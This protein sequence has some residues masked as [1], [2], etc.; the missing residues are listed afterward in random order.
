MS[1]FDFLADPKIL[2]VAENAAERVRARV[3]A[4]VRGEELLGACLDD[5]RATGYHTLT[6]PSALGGLG[7]SVLDACIAQERL[8]A[9][10]GS[11]GLAA[12]M[13]LTYIG[14]TLVS[15]LWP[16][17]RLEAFLRGVVEQGW[18]INN[19]QAE[20]K[21]GSP[22]RGGLPATT[23][24]RVE[25]GWRVDGRKRWS[26]AA[27]FLTHYAVGATVR[28]PG[29]PEHLGHFLVTAGAPGV[30]IDPTWHALTMRE[31]ASHDVVFEG[32]FVP[33]GDALY[34][35]ATGETFGRN[36]DQAPWHGLTFS[37]TYLGIAV[38]ARDWAVRFAAM[39][40]PTNLGSP[41]GDLPAVRAKIGEMEA[42]LLTA[43]RMIFDTGR[44][45]VEAKADRREVAAQVPLVKHVATNAAVRIT[46][47]ALR[48]A[49]A[50]GLSEEHPL[51]RCFRDVRSAL[52]HP[53]LDDVALEGAARRALADAANEG[54]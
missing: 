2:A 4:G 15:G 25:G 46:D 49:G 32:V 30:S 18:L 11:A 39:R 8:S 16:P 42:L 44:D 27:P 22:A 51:E 54:T 28:S 13:H 36:L 17:A 40:A 24:T 1:S 29:V 20:A 31:S 43:R 41:I 50:V 34:V 12:N 21:M 53:P 26:T 19:L 23:A 7:G 38:E 45:W 9:A 52:I 10:L 37:A 3:A 33:D 6:V 14:S 48:V 5:I 47:L 35:S